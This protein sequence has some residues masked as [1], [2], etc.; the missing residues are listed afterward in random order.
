MTNSSFIIS[1]DKYGKENYNQI[2]GKSMVGYFKH[3]ELYKID[4]QGNSET[5]YFVREE[6]GALIGINKAMASSMSIRIADRQLTDIYYYDKPDAHLIPE[7]S[8]P[9]QGLKLK[10]FIWLGSERPKNRYD[11]FKWESNSP[12]LK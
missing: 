1:I 7:D 10:N 12:V 3:N 8:F 4:V 2:K 6:D 9:E 11:I 5:L